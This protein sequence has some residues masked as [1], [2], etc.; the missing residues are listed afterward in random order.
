MGRWTMYCCDPVVDR[1]YQIEQGEERERVRVFQSW[2]VGGFWC[3]WVDRSRVDQYRRIKR[4]GQRRGATQHIRGG[5]IDYYIM[6]MK[7]T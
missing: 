5:W 1:I 6:G 7:Q 3:K 2:G 4:V